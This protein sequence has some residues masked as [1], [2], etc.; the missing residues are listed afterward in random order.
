LRLRVLLLMA[1]PQDN[2]SAAQVEV[3][4][5]RRWASQRLAAVQAYSRIL[6]D[7]GAGRTTTSAAAAA[8]ARLVAEETVRYSADAIGLAADVAAALVRRA[9]GQLETG[10]ARVSPVQD[11]ELSAPIGSEALSSF[12]LHNPRDQPAA[13][14]FVSSRFT[15]TLGDTAAKVA[16][17]PK[18]VEL[19]AG[20]EQPVSVSVFVDPAVFEPGG[21]YAASV[22]ISGF[23][24][25]VLRVRLSV[26][27]S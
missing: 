19:A 2:R 20:A 8:Y 10:R 9:G 24:D 23:D 13:L 12:M 14:S 4:L 15:G 25:F 21:L 11:L 1:A 26:L 18:R 27:P 6:S 22:S 7:Y 16:L 5:A 3:D 17:D